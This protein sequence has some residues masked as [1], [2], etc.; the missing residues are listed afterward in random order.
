MYRSPIG[1]FES[2]KAEAFYLNV[3]RQM[4]A[5]KKWRIACELWQMAVDNA[6]G[7]ARRE[8]P[9]WT[10]AQ[11]RAEIAHRILGSGTAR[12]PVPRH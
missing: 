2:E 10:E 11:V 1:D 9:D 6:R 4:S 5:D 7:Q 8:H 12:L 3:V